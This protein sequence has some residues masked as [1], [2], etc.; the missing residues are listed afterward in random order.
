M[1]IAT[2]LDN[3]IGVF[4]ALVVGTATGDWRGVVFGFL[5][6]SLVGIGVGIYIGKKD[7]RQKRQKHK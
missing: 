4:G 6:G 7:A 3:T 2:M 5:C 1:T